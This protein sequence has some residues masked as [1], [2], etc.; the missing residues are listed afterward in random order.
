MV[1]SIW[2]RRLSDTYLF[3][4]LDSSIKHKKEVRR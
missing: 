3:E 2:G 1:K 4:C